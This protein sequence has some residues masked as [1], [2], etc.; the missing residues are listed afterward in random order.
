MSGTQDLAPK[1]LWELDLA[2]YNLHWKPEFTEL[3]AGFLTGYRRVRALSIA[4][5]RHLELFMGLR[6][7]QMMLWA[8]EMR[9]HPA[10]RDSW[11]ADVREI[12]KALRELV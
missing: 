12:M 6:D 10:F 7:F 8:I 1:W 2:L 11:E 5:E 3:R 9:D 4:D